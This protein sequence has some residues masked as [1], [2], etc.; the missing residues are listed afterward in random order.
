M[1]KRKKKYSGAKKKVESVVATGVLIIIGL[2][3]YFFGPD[4]FNDDSQ[5]TGKV[6]L[7]GTMQVHFIDVGQGD[8]ALI[9]TPDGKNILVDAGTNSSEKDLKFYLDSQDIKEIEYAVMTHPH[10]DHIGG[11]DM[12]MNTY[13]VK[14]VIMPDVTHD[15]VTFERMLEAIDRNN[16][17]L[18]TSKLGD[19]YTV[20]DVSFKI[21]APVNAK[22]SS[23]ND[24]SVVIRVEYGGTSFM[25]TGDAEKLSEKEM[26]AKHNIS[27]FACDV[28]KVGH[29]GSTTSTSREFL[30]AINPTAAI[31]S[32]GTGNTYGHPHRET[33]DSL[34]DE[35]V[36]I[37]RV[38]Q[39]GSIVF[40]ADGA[41]ITYN[42]QKVA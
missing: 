11:A 31:I 23:L 24:Y 21:L 25:F 9:V 22:Y 26:L 38:D 2:I 40:K 10:E 28:L 34:V 29:H 1:A 17:N 4:M 20:G 19:V 35:G 3:V 13:D 12:V 15:S 16:V 42:N 37:Y 14:N 41:E 5:R 39:L 36:E 32:C 30:S 6:V 8:S 33:I 27:E 18:I 7:D